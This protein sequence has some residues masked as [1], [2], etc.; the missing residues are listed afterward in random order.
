M[1][2]GV[3][4]ETGRLYLILQKKLNGA[5]LAIGV[6]RLDYTND[7]DAPIKIFG[8]RVQCGVRPRN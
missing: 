2:F 6:D 3:A 5:K 7:I 8:L 1:C 4:W